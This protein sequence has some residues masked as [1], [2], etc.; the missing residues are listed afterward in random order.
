[1]MVIIS[2]WFE[3]VFALG[4][5][6]GWRLESGEERVVGAHDAQQRI[7]RESFSMRSSASYGRAQH[8][9]RQKNSNLIQHPYL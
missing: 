7:L 9:R 8:L 5:I 3:S 1:L 2:Q 6:G 4:Q